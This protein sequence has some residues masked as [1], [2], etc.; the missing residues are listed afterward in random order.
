MAHRSNS[1]RRIE[2]NVRHGEEKDHHDPEAKTHSEKDN[3]QGDERFKRGDK[4][5]V[6]IHTQKI[7]D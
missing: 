6:E 7:F 1:G 2:D 5:C 3:Q 4:K